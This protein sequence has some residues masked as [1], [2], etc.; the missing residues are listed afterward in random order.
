MA[1]PV[2]P[3][4]TV[5]QTVQVKKSRTEKGKEIKYFECSKCQS[6]W[7]NSIDIASLPVVA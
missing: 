1:E 7:T 2:C 4:C 3:K 6:L 5:P